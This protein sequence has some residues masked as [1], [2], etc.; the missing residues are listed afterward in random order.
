MKL[1][2]CEQ[3]NKQQKLHAQVV[4]SKNAR[5]K[6]TDELVG[7]MQV[8]YDELLNEMKEACTTTRD[9]TKYAK[10]LHEHASSAHGNMRKQMEIINSLKDEICDEQQHSANLEKKVEECKVIIDCSYD[11]YDKREHEFNDIIDYIDKYYQEEAVKYALK[12]ITKHFM[13]N[14]G[15]GMLSHL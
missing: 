14:K 10:Q 15:R 5:L 12:F 3:L 4:H 8:M 7:G 2:H 11:E 6:S 1:S 13:Q 9:S